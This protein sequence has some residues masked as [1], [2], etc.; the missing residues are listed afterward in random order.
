VE[1]SARPC[2]LM[3][4]AELFAQR[5]MPRRPRASYFDLGGGGGLEPV[6]S[7]RTRRAHRLGRDRPALARHHA[8]ARD[9]WRPTATGG[10]PQTIGLKSGSAAR[11]NRPGPVQLRQIE[12]TNES[13]S[14]RRGRLESGPNLVGA[15]AASGECWSLAELARRRMNYCFHSDLDVASMFA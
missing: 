10:R 4:L 11:L 12:L 5:A 1:A 14:S 8:P 7:G 15:A 13:Q 2:L 3:C 6:R 9:P